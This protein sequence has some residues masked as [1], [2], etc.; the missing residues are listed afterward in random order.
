MY[1]LKL[2]TCRRATLDHGPKGYFLL[3]TLVG[4]VLE[5]WQPCLSG[6]PQHGFKVSDNYI[7]PNLKSC[8]YHKQIL[9][10]KCSPNQ[11]F[12]KCFQA[13]NSLFNVLVTTSKKY[14]CP[15]ILKYFTIKDNDY[16][17]DLHKQRPLPGLC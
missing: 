5:G 6:Q 3:R 2:P 13:L 9:W 12:I 17:H 1:V 4:E 14:L 10:F 8:C 11:P 16:D 15:I 7:F